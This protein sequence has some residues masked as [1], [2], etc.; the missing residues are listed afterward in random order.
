MKLILVPKEMGV[1]YADAD[2]DHDED[3]DDEENV[4]DDKGNRVSQDTI[5]SFTSKESSIFTIPRISKTASSS[6]ST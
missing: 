4:E 6:P 2:D 5:E 1:S 3:D